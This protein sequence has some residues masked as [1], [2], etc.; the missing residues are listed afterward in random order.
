MPVRSQFLAIADCLASIK[1]AAKTAA[2][3]VVS[4]YTGTQP[5]ASVGIFAAPYAWWEGGLAWNHLIEYATLTGDTQYNTLVSNAI[6]A[7]VGQNQDF[8]P[9]NQSKTEGNDDQAVWALAALTAAEVGFPN[10]PSGSPAWL[11]LAEN[12]FNDQAA[13]WNTANCSGGLRWQIFAFNNGYNYVNSD[14]NGQFFLL[15]ARLARFTGN[16]TYSDWATKTYDWMSSIG[17]VSTQG[18]VYDGADIALNCSQ[19]DH[20]QWSADSGYVLEGAANMYNQVC[21]F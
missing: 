10:P 17:I 20:I 9:A 7:Q 16:T 18:E 4:Y 1:A 15:A 8:M 21:T 12:V 11:E 2:G 6:L 13:R 19:I 14:S 5:G 3:G